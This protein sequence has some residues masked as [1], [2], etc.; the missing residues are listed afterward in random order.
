MRALKSVLPGHQPNYI[1]DCD[2]MT[3]DRLITPHRRR[4]RWDGI[5]PKAFAGRCGDY[6]QDKVGKVFPGFKAEAADE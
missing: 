3:P 6:L 5:D 4:E 1:T 2:T